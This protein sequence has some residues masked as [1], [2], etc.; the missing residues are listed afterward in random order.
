MT[1]DISKAKA[2]VAEFQSALDSAAQGAETQA[3]C[4]E[5]LAP[6]HSYQGVRPIYDLKGPEALADALWTPYKSS[7]TAHQRRHDMVFASTDHLRADGALWVVCMGNHLGDMTGDWLG[8]PAQKKTVFM[9]YASFYRVEG[10]IIA[11]TIEFHDVLAVLTQAGL[12]TT[13]DHQPGAYLMSPGPMTGLGPTRR[14]RRQR[15][16]R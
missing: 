9:P 13:I 3:V 16:S 6:D 14:R 10:A 12:N 11:E 8:I 4:A 5:F 7:L 2:L 1:T 15:H